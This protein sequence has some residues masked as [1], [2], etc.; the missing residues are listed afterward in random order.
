[1]I[2]FYTLLI[3]FLSHCCFVGC[4][5]VSTTKKTTIAKPPK[6]KLIKSQPKYSYNI[7]EHIQKYNELVDDIKKEKRYYA[8]QNDLNRVQKITYTLLNDSIFPYWYGTTWDF[9]GTTET[10]LQGSIACGYF[11][12]TTLRDA[13]F[14]V[15]RISWAQEPSSVLIQKVCTPASIKMFSSVELLKN[16]LNNEP[17]QNLYILGLDNHV[18]FVSKENDTLFFIHS[19]YSGEQMVKKEFLENAV[20]ILNSKSFLIGNILNNRQLLQKWLN[21]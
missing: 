2:K 12:T 20:P 10:P 8:R 19:S 1:M 16:H 5:S 11:V 15:Q 4:E 3:L 14:P 7:E 9:N 6:Q 17:N 18:G 21:Y 13:G